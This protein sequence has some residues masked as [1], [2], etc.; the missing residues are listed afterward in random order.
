MIRLAPLAR[1]T[2]APSQR[3]ARHVNPYYT[4]VVSDRARSSKRQLE[5]LKETHN[6]LKAARIPHWLAGGWAIDFL[7]GRVTRQ[8]SDV[9]FAI[10]ND[11]WRRV[12]ALL[13]ANEFTLRVNEFPDETGRLVHKGTHFEFYLL[14]KNA[15]GDIRWR[16]LDRLAIFPMTAGMQQ[17]ASNHFLYQ[18]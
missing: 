16:A 8:H 1:P 10:W 12:E 2:A 3:D 14:Q 6:L 11:D 9:D 7:M 5:H 13:L 15:A 18:S 4:N 17:A